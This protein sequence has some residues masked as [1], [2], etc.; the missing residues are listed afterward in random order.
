MTDPAERPVREVTVLIGGDE[1]ARI[2]EAA[3]GLG[4]SPDALMESAG[5][6]V[7]ELALAELA[8]MTEP[9]VGP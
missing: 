6:A 1:M 3:Q 5:T 7:T 2:D 8:A 9:I 4:L